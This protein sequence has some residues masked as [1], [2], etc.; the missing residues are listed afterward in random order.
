MT[1]LLGKN[2]H[3]GSI[4]F[5]RFRSLVPRELQRGTARFEGPV[6]NHPQH[7]QDD[8]ITSHSPCYGS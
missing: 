5:A 8:R 4:P 3:E 1:T 2:G 6:M 7:A